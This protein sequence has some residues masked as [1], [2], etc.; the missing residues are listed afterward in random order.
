MN[1]L[2]V[3]EDAYAAADAILSGNYQD[4]TG[5]ATHYYNPD[6]LLHGVL[7]QIRVVVSGQP[8]GTTSLETL[9]GSGLLLLVLW[10]GMF[11]VQSPPTRWVDRLLL[12]SLLLCRLG[13]G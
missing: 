13:L 10:K 8:S 12:T 5:G 11:P 6:Q 2:R 3:S 1:S 4:P 9:M 7:V